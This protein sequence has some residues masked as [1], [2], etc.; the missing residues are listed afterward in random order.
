MQK[1]MKDN[2]KCHLDICQPQVDYVTLN[3]GHATMEKVDSHDIEVRH[4]NRSS[5]P[6]PSPPRL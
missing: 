3:I 4:M 1:G 2:N 5:S 6:C